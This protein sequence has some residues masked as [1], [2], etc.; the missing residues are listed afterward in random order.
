MFL[1]SSQVNTELLIWDPTSSSKCSDNKRYFIMSQSEESG[2]DRCEVVCCSIMATHVVSVCDSPGL[3]ILQI[4]L[5]GLLIGG[6]KRLFLL[7]CSCH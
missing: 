5:E 6:R 7:V 2:G 4:P 1:T 3:E